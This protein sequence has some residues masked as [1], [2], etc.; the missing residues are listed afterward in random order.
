MIDLLAFLAFMAVLLMDF[1]KTQ[2]MV[3]LVLIFT[4]IGAGVYE[5]ATG[6]AS[7]FFVW[8]L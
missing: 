8:P 7:G 5:I 2:A 6:F 4:A 1:P 3:W